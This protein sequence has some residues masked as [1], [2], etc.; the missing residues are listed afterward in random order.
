MKLFVATFCAKKKNLNREPKN[1]NYLHLKIPPA[2]W[3]VNNHL[4]NPSIFLYIDFTLK[5]T[6]TTTTKTNGL[7]NKNNINVP[8]GQGDE[9]NCKKNNILSSLYNHTI[10]STYQE[11]IK[12]KHTHIIIIP[13][14]SYTHVLKHLWWS[15]FYIRFYNFQTIILTYYYTKKKT[16]YIIVTTKY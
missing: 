7:K 4:Y 3:S 9:L 2:A 1:V 8:A 14:L 11:L 16:T 15:L 12:N 5:A 6:L 10:L 13:V